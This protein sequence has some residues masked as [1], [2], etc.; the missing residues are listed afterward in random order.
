LSKKLLDIGLLLIEALQGHQE[1]ITDQ[2]SFQDTSFY[3]YGE[4]WCGR[5]KPWSAFLDFT[6]PS[7]DTSKYICLAEAKNQHIG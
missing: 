5:L 2:S 3:F 7:E 4:S 6:Q 1:I